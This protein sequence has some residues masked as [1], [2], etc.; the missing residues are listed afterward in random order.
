[1]DK[2]QETR[3][4]LAFELRE[5]LGQWHALTI[6]RN[7]TERDYARIGARIH[8]VCSALDKLDEGVQ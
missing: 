2:T 3:N 5:L 4:A 7:A 8:E 1:M 6:N